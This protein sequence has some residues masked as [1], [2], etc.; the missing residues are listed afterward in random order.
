MRDVIAL[1]LAF[2]LVLLVL[3]PQQIGKIVASIQNGYEQARNSKPEAP[4]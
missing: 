3:E 1:I 4:Q 2:V